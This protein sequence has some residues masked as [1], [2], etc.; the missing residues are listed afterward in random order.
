MAKIYRTTDRISLKV[1][2]LTITVSPL[3]I[4]QKT[5]VE[6]LASNGGSSSAIKAAVCAMKF[7]IKS[8]SGLEGP[9]GSPYQLEFDTD[10]TLADSV[11]DDL[12]NTKTSFKL[13]SICLNLINSIPDEFYDPNTGKRLEGVEFIADKEK[14]SRKK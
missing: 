12:F 14:P 10:G 3:S 8:V 5:A 11:V 2:D 9:D 13:M 6:E 7:A 1:D 4:H